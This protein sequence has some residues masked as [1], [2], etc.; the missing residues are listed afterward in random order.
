MNITSVGA[1]S[2]NLW[3]TFHLQITPPDI[4]INQEPARLDIRQQR[5]ELFIDQTECFAEKG[6]QP[7]LQLATSMAQESLNQSMAGIERRIIEGDQLGRIE[8]RGASLVEVLSR[9]EPKYTD[10]N[11]DLAPKTP[12]QIKFITHPTE[13]NVT[14]GDIKVALT[15]GT[16]NVDVDPIINITA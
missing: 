9:W 1:P 7:S 4:Q 2:R 12:P 3:A 10:Y 14:L 8:N 11:V 16:I 6:S 13:I 15:Y 5:P